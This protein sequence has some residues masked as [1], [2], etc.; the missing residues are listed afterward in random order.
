M[1]ESYLLVISDI[2]LQLDYLNPFD[3]PEDIV[4]QD[5]IIAGSVTIAIAG[6]SIFLT[7]M[8]VSAY[9]KTGVSQLKYIALAFSLFTIYLGTEALQELFTFDDDSFDLF[10]S[11]IMMFILIS[12]FF[13]IMRKKKNQA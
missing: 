11:I 13:G 4:T 1:L 3:D 2:F 5:D 9:R 7:I 12:F 10:L 8:A 6:L